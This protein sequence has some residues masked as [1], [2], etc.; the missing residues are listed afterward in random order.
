MPPALPRDYSSFFLP[1]KEKNRCVGISK[2]PLIVFVMF[3]APMLLKIYT[4]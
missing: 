2:H 1:P 3:I 4:K